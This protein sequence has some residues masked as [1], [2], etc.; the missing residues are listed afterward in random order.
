MPDVGAKGQFRFIVMAG[1][2]HAD[3]YNEPTALPEPQNGR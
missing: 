3:T 2:T 1:Q